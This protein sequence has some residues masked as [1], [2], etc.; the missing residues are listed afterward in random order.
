[1][2]DG[3]RTYIWSGESPCATTRQRSRTAPSA[4]STVEVAAI[5][6]DNARR[7][8]QVRWNS[9]SVLSTGNAAVF[10]RVRALEAFGSRRGSVRLAAASRS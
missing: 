4:E 9:S 5:A 1:M 3:K 7:D 10:I 2:I 6:I 8:R